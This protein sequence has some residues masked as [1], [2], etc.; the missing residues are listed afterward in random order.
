ME[1]EKLK[2]VYISKEVHREIKKLAAEQGKTIKEIA[3]ELIKK[4]LREN[5][6]D[7]DQRR[8]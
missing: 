2:C 7:N 5:D 3:E 1:D 8:H 6:R 4:E